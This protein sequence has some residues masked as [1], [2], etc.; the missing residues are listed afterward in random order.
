MK[1]FTVQS[2]L[3]THRKTWSDH[4]FVLSVITGFL[5]FIASLFVN[6]G[7][8]VYSTKEAGSAVTDILLQNLPVVNTDIIF[9]EGALV[10][11]VF[12]VTLGILK[13]KIIPFTLKSIALFICIRSLFVI[14]T[15]LGPDP[16]HI[17]TDFNRLRYI[18]AGADLF[19]SG[20]T[21]LP[22][23][24]A[25]LFW[26]DSQLRL[27]FLTC[28]LVAGVAVILGHLHYTIDVFSAFFITYGIYHISQKA[29]QK[30]W[31]IFNEK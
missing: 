13:P 21:G 11:V 30:D 6:Y 29:F 1:N 7:A 3:A 17:A 27:I 19:F 5:F 24:L 18:S 20:H 28:S 15:H 8:V 4:F 22:F 2:L 31:E 16:G 26:K 10:F 14:M 12:V 9:S 23:L 25:L